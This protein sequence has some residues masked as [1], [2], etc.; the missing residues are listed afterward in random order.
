MSALT[1]MN[2]D[3]RCRSQAMT[4]KISKVWALGHTIHNTREQLPE[5]KLY[6]ILHVVVDKITCSLLLS[7]CYVLILPSPE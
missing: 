7:S 6:K 3:S 5:Q 1:S 2:T 4:H